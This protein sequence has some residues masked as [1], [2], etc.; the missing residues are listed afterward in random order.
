MKNKHRKF[1]W[2]ASVMGGDPRAG[3]GSVVG[4][5]VIPE[6]EEFTFPARPVEYIWGHPEIQIRAKFGVCDAQC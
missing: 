1:G 5:D 6:G 2:A 4:E 3:V